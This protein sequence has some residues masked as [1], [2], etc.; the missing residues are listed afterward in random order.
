MVSYATT[1][2]GA[3]NCSITGG[4]VYRGPQYPFL[5]GASVSH[6]HGGFDNDCAT[7]NSVLTRVLGS[8]PKRLFTGRDL[9]Y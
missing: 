5:Q 2:F 6:S 1:R 9:H 7:M 8:A 4:F 3:G